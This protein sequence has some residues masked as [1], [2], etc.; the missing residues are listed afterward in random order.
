MTSNAE[1]QAAYRARHR[2]EGGGRINYAVTASAEFGLKRL[3][4]HYGV[5]RKAMLE[6]LIADAESGLLDKMSRAEMNAYFGE[7]GSPNL[8]SHK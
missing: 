6:T 3:A 7:N 2:E 4:A 8:H 5:T 1:R